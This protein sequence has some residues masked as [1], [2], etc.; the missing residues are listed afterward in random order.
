MVDLQTEHQDAQIKTKTGRFLKSDSE[1]ASPSRLFKVKSGAEK[2]GKGASRE[3]SDCAGG[4]KIG[5]SAIQIML[6]R[7]LDRAIRIKVF[8]FKIIS[9][10]FG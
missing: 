2:P 3:V 1:Y 10:N 7:I 5:V 6:S 4:K 8:V 9:L